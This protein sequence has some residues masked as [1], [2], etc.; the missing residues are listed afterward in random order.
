MGTGSI[1]EEILK[2]EKICR[3]KKV[4][5][6]NYGYIR[7]QKKKTLLIT[8]LLFAIPLTIY[9]T[10]FII[11]KTRLNLFTFV[12]ILGCLPACKSMVSLIVILMQKSAP[13]QIFEETRRISSGLTTAYEL[14]FTTYEHTS[15]VNAL[16]ICGNQIL[17]YTPDEKTDNSHLEKHI[18]RILTANGYSG[19]L[20]KVMKD[21]KKFLQRVEEIS[22]KQD[23]LREGISF[24]PDD[25]Y[26]NLSREE[27]IL[28]V[29]LAISL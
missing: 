16:V 11:T 21:Y 17:C 5:K 13:R 19:T 18:S 8:L 3:M 20:P 26:P 1:S 27:L 14:V 12:A 4:K 7:F 29:L 23:V 28:H 9:A 6:G 24:T 25:R 22:R 2:K 10:G 15:P